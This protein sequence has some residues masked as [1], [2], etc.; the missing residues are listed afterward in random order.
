M[1][2]IEEAIEALN[3][4]KSLQEESNFHNHPDYASTLLTLGRCYEK[5]GNKLLAIQFYEKTISILENYKDNTEIALSLN[6]SKVAL[7]KLQ[8]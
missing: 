2:V 5:Q 1:V 4:A 3:I 6:E 7:K 8:K